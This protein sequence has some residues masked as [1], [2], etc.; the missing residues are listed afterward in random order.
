MGGSSFIVKV[1]IEVECS[2][3]MSLF[4]MCYRSFTGKVYTLA[5][6]I[7]M[8]SYFFKIRVSIFD[9]VVQSFFLKFQVLPW[10]MQK[11]LY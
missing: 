11:S 3:F 2:A 10:V 7:G 1:C 8:E 4:F 5:T 6:V 9:C